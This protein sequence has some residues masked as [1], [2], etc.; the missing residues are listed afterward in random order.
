MNE[1]LDASTPTTVTNLDAAKKQLAT[2]IRLFF[3][4]DDAVSIHTL[5]SAAREIFEKHCAQAG[6]KRTFDYVRDENP[7]YTEKQLW[8]ILNTPSKT[9]F[10]HA[11]N[12]ELK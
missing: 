9:N 11:N 1:A 7:E 12:N 6:L 4:R 2:A 5:A 8:N 10:T 3:A